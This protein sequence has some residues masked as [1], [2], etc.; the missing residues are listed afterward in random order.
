MT[1]NFFLKSLCVLSVFIYTSSVFALEIDEKLT[2]RILKSSDS[3]KTILV[4]RGIEDGLAKGDHAKFFLSV[5]V[6]ARAV[7]IKASPTRTVWSVYRV[8][9]AD[10]IRADQVM[11]LKITRPVKISADPTKMMATDDTPTS[12]GYEDPRDLGIPLAEGADD[13]EDSSASS[14]DDAG[15]DALFAADIRGRKME[16]ILGLFLANSSSTALTSKN[17]KEYVSSNNDTSF[18]VGGEYYFGRSHSFLG[19]ISVFGTFGVFQRSLLAYQGANVVERSNEL[20]VGG[21]WSLSQYHDKTMSL[22]PY[23]SASYFVGSVSS[24]YN[25]GSEDSSVAAQTNS[26]NYVGYAIGG[27]VKYYLSNGFGARLYLDYRTQVDSYGT[28]NTGGTWQVRK[29]GPLAAFALSYRF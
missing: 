11:N 8:V 2:L 7:V 26:G 19:R 13:D 14:S 10:Y 21:T 4:N 6:V 15:E 16:I 28:D 24:E 25:R 9:N 29:A 17:S 5:G 3:R 18:L 22:L 27:G 20:Q 1:K 12:I 23:V